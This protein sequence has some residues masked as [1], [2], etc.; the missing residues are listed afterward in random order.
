[1]CICINCRHV[2]NCTT[3]IVVQKQ[4]K[5]N[6]T[7]VFHLYFTPPDTLIEANLYHDIGNIRIEWDI[8]E[9]LSF[10]ERPAYWLM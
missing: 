7:R 6:S 9:C 10:V 4:H 3:Y 8:V 2:R 1:M 5:K